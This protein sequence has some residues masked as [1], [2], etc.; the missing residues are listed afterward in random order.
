LSKFQCSLI[1]MKIDIHFLFSI[2][3]FRHLAF[4]QLGQ[5]HI[6]FLEWNPMRTRFDCNVMFRGD[7]M[8]KLECNVT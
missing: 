3:S 8:G 2:Y 5:G 4:I 6:G 1:S 7:Y